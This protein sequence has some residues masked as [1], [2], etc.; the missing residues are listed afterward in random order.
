M[1]ILNADDTFY[2]AT[3]FAGDF[4]IIHNFAPKDV[5]IEIHPGTGSANET[6]F[7]NLF[8]SLNP[9]RFDINAEGSFAWYPDNSTTTVVRLRASFP[10]GITPSSPDR[11]NQLNSV[12]LEYTTDTA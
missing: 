9:I 8:G 5:N 3:I 6:V 7:T 11:G 12:F 1:A 2:T 10:H 4:L